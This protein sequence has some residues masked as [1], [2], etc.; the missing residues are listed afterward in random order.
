MDEN[1]LIERVT[2]K[3]QIYKGH[4]L[5]VQKWTVTLPNGG[6]AYRE[7]DL[8]RGAVA[9]VAVDS[10]KNVYL[11]RQY[12]V[13]VGKLLDEIPAGK[14]DYIGEDRLSAAQ[15]ELKEET[16]FTAGKWTKLTDIYTTPG[17]TNELITIYLAEDLTGGDTDFDEDEFLDLIKLPFAEAVKNAACGVYEDSKT[18]AGLLIAGARIE[19]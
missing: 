12:R 3:E 7:V 14:L 6:T 19:R 13:A 1:A 10:E 16:G 2:G 9:V 18:I 5:D 8:H 11:V 4:I 17:F 15:R